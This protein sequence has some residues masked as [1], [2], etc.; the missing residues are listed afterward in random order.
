MCIE[1]TEVIEEMG[2][3]VNCVGEDVSECVEGVSEKLG[4]N[5]T[6]LNTQEQCE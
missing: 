2:A 4:S 1:I 3:L 6:L 5:S